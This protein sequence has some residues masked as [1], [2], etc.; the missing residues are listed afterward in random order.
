MRRGVVQSNTISQFLLHADNVVTSFEYHHGLKN[1]IEH[2]QPIH[3]LKS[4]SQ[5]MKEINHST[6]TPG[7]WLGW[8]LTGKELW[9]ESHNPKEELPCLISS[10]QTCGV[11]NLS[12]WYWF[13]RICSYR[14]HSLNLKSGVNDQRF[15]LEV[16]MCWQ[17]MKAQLLQTIGISSRSCIEYLKI[18]PLY[19]RSGLGHISVF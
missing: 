14:E 13:Q 6:G 11:R 10:R 19:P 7:V 16:T 8:A 9:R 5:E 17:Y 18:G 15:H 12:T 3:R 2:E 1:H 4:E